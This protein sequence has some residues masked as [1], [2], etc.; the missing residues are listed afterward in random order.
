ML[1]NLLYYYLFRFCRETKP[2]N[3]PENVTDK[4]KEIHYELFGHNNDWKNSRFTDSTIK[5]KVCLFE[6]S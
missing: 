1:T 4:I 3:P 2:Y 6:L 5:F